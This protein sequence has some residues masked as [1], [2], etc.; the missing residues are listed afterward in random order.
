MNFKNRMLSGLLGLGLLAVPAVAVAGHQDGGRAY[1]G[2]YNYLRQQQLAAPR[3][4]NQGRD[5][6]SRWS[7]R[8][9]DGDHDSDWRW[10]SN[11]DRDDYCD[12]G[13]PNLGANQY[14]A[15][16][17]AARNNARTRYAAAL[18]SGRRSAAQQWLQAMRHLDDRINYLD[19]RRAG[20]RRYFDYNGGFPVATGQGLYGPGYD[21]DLYLNN[22]AGAFQSLAPLFNPGVR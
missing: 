6:D 4:N 1:P 18:R 21:P 19:R 5:Y 16:L 11:R 20:G 13:R 7:N 14:R 12:T 10:Q 8:D 15:R 17:V 22:L 3:W 9:R 2:A